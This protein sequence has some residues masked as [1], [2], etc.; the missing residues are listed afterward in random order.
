MYIITFFTIFNLSWCVPYSLTNSFTCFCRWLHR[1]YIIDICYSLVHK[2]H[3]E[4]HKVNVTVLC[5]LLIYATSLRVYCRNQLGRWYSILK[6]MTLTRIV[7][8]EQC[9]GINNSSYSIMSRN[10]TVSWQRNTMDKLEERITDDLFI[11]QH[12]LQHSHRFIPSCKTAIP[13]WYETV[14]HTT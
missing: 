14:T 1:H 2:C 4:M 11:K 9:N 6:C 7:A 5:I 3:A 8:Y 12:I 10:T 13:Q